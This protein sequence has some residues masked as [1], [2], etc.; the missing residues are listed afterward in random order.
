MGWPVLASDTFPEMVCARR[1]SELRKSKIVNNCFIDVW[2]YKT[3]MML[4]PV[5]RTWVS[6]GIEPSLNL[7]D[8]SQH[9]TL[10]IAH[11]IGGQVF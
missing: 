2:L 8:V 1:W 4:T 5:L 10:Q 11:L 9:F 6:Y 7:T 3:L